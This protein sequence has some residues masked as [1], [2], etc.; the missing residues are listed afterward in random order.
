MGAVLLGQQE[1]GLGEKHG[2]PA[3]YG[4]SRGSAGVM[5]LA[6]KPIFSYWGLSRG[7]AGVALTLVARN[8][9]HDHVSRSG[10]KLPIEEHL[11]FQ[12]CK[13]PRYKIT[14]QVS[15]FVPHYL[16]CDPTPRE[17]CSKVARKKI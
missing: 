1:W 12:H 5:F 9:E 6:W 15:I 14:P 10:S 4:V 17:K 16:K 2:C 3:K 8:M 11:G 7:S 13:F